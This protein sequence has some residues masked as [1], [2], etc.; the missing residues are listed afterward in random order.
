MRRLLHRYARSHARCP[1]SQLL[2]ATSYR[3]EA[4]PDSGHVLATGYRK[5]GTCSVS[6]ALGFASPARSGLP[7]EADAHSSTS[8]H[9]R[10]GREHRRGRR[11]TRS[12]APG[13][14]GRL[15]G[16]ARRTHTAT[17]GRARPPPPPRGRSESRNPG[18]N[19]ES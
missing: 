2:Q 12:H 3:G 10:R 5:T 6:F 16:E 1:W 15:R 13:E 9:A 19:Q 11:C 18:V 4:E 7:C 17:A 14:G 8:R